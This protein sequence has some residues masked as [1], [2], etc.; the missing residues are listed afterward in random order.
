MV[1]YL[2]AA[3]LGCLYIAGSIWIVQRAGTEYRAGLPQT[4]RFA[5]EI[6]S[7]TRSPGVK[8]KDSPLAPAANLTFAPSKPALSDLA[9][10]PVTVAS[11]KTT[12]D[13]PAP[14]APAIEVA[15]VK[16]VIAPPK[17]NANAHPDGKA[18]PIDPLAND[19]FWNKPELKQRWEVTHLKTDDERQLRDILHAVIVHFNPL[20]ADPSP[21]VSRVEEAAEPFYPKLQRK[22]I[23]YKFFILDSDVVNAF[24]IPGGNVYISR[25]L[26]NLIGKDED[27]ALEFA[28]GHEIAHV[29]L[30]HA[31][32]CLRMPGMRELP[33]GTM[34]KIFLLILPF[35]YVANEKVN[36]EFAADDW[37]RNKMTQ[38]GRT[39]R[40]I[41][42]FLQKLEGY[43]RDHGFF[44]GRMPPQLGRDLSP[45]ENHYRAQISARERLKHLKE[46]VGQSATAPR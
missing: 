36:Q 21:W 2:I 24:S 42:V 26:F 32:E 27:Y 14:I 29:D 10:P 13:H 9:P 15:E 7:N 39:R 35:G 3:V 28:I 31:I 16:S 23:K 34:F 38:I 20:V 22:E 30:E 8:D 37:V 41:L 5:V 45:V 1:R 6:A 43:S 46:L 19:P 44:G 17:K 40:E 11:R 4:K 25:G 12:A 18:A 33:R